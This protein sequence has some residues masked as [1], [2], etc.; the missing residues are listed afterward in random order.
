M[1]PID[2]EL[3]VPE[4]KLQELDNAARDRTVWGPQCHQESADS[5]EHNNIENSLLKI[6]TA[7]I[8]Q[9]KIQRLKKFIYLFFTFLN[10]PSSSKYLY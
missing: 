10:R 5:T 7:D 3:D 2:G 6:L 8:L 4:M 1:R 9:V